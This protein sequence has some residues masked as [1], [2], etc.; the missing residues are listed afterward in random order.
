M[1]EKYVKDQYQSS[2]SP[3]TNHLVELTYN[4]CQ[5]VFVE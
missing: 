3:A 1:E 5:I 4:T 2:F